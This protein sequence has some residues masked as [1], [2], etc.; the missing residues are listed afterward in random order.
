MNKFNNLNSFLGCSFLEQSVI[1]SCRFV[2]IHLLA[3]KSRYGLILTN[4]QGLEM[5]AETPRLLHSQR[6]A[7]ES[8]IGAAKGTGLSEDGSASTHC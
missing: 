6:R 3:W 1:K 2:E 5:Y 8:A 7:E 4:L